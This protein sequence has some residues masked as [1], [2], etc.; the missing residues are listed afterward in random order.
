MVMVHL[1]QIPIAPFHG[2]GGPLQGPRFPIRQ[3]VGASAW[4][5]AWWSNAARTSSQASCILAFRRRQR[6]RAT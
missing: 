2:R 1:R 6:V 4:V 3:H 5:I